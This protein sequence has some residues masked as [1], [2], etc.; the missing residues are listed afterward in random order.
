VLRTGSQD[1]FVAGTGREKTLSVYE[2]A[3]HPQA[4]RNP[5]QNPPRA[6]STMDLLPSG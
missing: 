2:S 6:H 3:K 4:L 1:A 5:R